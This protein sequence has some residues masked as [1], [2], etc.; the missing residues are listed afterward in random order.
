MIFKSFFL[1]VHVI[2]GI[3]EVAGLVILRT[4]CLALFL[5][6]GTTLRTGTTLATLR[7]LT[8]LRTILT[9]TTLATLRTLATLT[10]CGTLYV[11]LGLRDEHTVREL[12]L[13][14]LRV[15]LKQLHGNLVAFLDA[16]FLDGLQ[17]FPVNL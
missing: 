17:T 4:I 13:A 8:T 10:T 16:G 6:T 14:G 11:A 1:E 7:T 9:R 5:E 2:E 3:A 15:N 12:V